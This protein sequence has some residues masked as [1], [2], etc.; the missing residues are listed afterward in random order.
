MRD[1]FSTIIYIESEDGLSFWWILWHRCPRVPRIVRWT[2]ACKR[3]HICAAFDK[4]WRLPRG[5]A[6]DC[7]YFHCFYRIEIRPHVYCGFSAQLQPL[8]GQGLDSCFTAL[9]QQVKSSRDC[10]LS[11]CLQVW[12][13]ALHV[14]ASSRSS[15]LHNPVRI[16]KTCTT[17]NCV[18]SFRNTL[19]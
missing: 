16:T 2:R 4:W 15:K 19:F 3:R 8:C 10:G 6:C 12:V 11:L 17:Q 13:P 14:S 9:T 7:F 5:S 1:S 18:W